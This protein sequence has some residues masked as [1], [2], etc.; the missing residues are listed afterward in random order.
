MD[1]LSQRHWKEP[2]WISKTAKFESDLLKTNEEIACQSHEM[3]QMG[4]PYKY[5]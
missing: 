5:L 2:L 4:T 1:K 3:L